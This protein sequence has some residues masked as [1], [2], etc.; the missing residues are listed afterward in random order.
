MEEPIAQMPL[1]FSVTMI[2]FKL[3]SEE[4]NNNNPSVLSQENNS[5]SNSTSAFKVVTPRG[6]TDGQF[7]IKSSCVPFNRTSKISE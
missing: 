7:H 3:K 4:N 6:K 5:T 2:N 1:D